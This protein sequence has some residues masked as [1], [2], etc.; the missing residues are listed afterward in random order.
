MARSK[1][2]SSASVKRKDKK[3]TVDCHVQYC[4]AID[5]QNSQSKNPG[6]TFFYFPKPEKK[7]HLAQSQINR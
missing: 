5:C 3:K 4:A 2:K 1:K 6:L 7:L